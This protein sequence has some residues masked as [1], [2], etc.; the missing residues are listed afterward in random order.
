MLAIWDDLQLSTEKC[1]SDAVLEFSLLI[2]TGAST[3]IQNEFYQ[4]R[5][6][7]SLTSSKFLNRIEYLHKVWGG[8]KNCKWEN[9]ND[10]GA[11]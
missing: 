3:F 5:F 7:N 6:A 8:S 1:Y 11:W 9:F 4:G 2:N 10:H